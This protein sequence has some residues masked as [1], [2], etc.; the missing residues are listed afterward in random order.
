CGLVVSVVI[1]A[2]LMKA[3]RLPGEYFAFLHA[4]ELP[5]RLFSGFSFATETLVKNNALIPSVVRLSFTAIVIFALIALFWQLS[6]RG[7]RWRGALLW[8]AVTSLIGLGF[9]WTIG[10]SLILRTYWPVPRNMA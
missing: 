8:S 9:W 3:L 1:G 4:R 7:G 5:E 6:V 10:L 2:V